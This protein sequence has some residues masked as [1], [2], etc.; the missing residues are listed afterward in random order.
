MKIDLNADLGEGAGNDEKIVDL[1]TSANICSGAYAGS[2]PEIRKTIAMCIKR[3]VTIGAHIGFYDPNHFG[4]REHPSPARDILEM[5]HH[6]IG[7]LKQIVCELGGVLK[8]VKPHG[9]LY[10][11]ANRDE[12]IAEAVVSAAALHSLAIIGLP[13]SRLQ[14]RSNGVIPFFAE[15]FADRGYQKDGSLIPRDHPDAFIDD[16]KL[17][18]EQVNRLIRDAKIRTVCVHGDNPKA[19]EFIISL[20]NSLISSGFELAAF[21]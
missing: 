8:Y 3:N 6:Q 19:L 4:R 21:A 2:E 15:G 18:V 9:G 14:M 13:D 5:C 16:P 10:H 11:Q 17:A 20:R 12:S 1:I 7:V